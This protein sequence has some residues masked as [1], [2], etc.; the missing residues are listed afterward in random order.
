MSDLRERFPLSVRR[1]SRYC[2]REKYRTVS[3]LVSLSPAQARL[4]PLFSHPQRMLPPSHNRFRSG[5]LRAL[6]LIGPLNFVVTISVIC[7]LFSFP[8]PPVRLSPVFFILPF[9][10]LNSSKVS[11]LVSQPVDVID[12]PTWVLVGLLPPVLFCLVVFFLFCS[13]GSIVPLLLERFCSFS[14]SDS[15]ASFDLFWDIPFSHF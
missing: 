10:S 6:F 3:S 15:R 8:S 12:H 13:L 1:F 4:F 9:S 7:P 14:F 11:F 5:S 2:S